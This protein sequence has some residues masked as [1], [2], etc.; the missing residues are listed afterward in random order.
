VA[1]RERRARLARVFTRFF[2]LPVVARRDLRAF[3]FAMAFS[4][5]VCG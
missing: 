3:F 2:N 1:G 5:A 4:L